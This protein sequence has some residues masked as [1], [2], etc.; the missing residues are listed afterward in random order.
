MKNQILS[1]VAIATLMTLTSCFNNTNKKEKEVATSTAKS[2]V[3]GLKQVD[4]LLADAE[5]LIGKEITVE[6]ICTHLCKHGGSKMFLMGDN[7][8]L[9]IESCELKS[10]PQSCVNSIVRV[11]GTV[12]EERIDEAYLLKWEASLKDEVQDNHGDGEN[13]CETEN[14][15]R[16]E[17]GNTPEERIA[18]FRRRIAERKA[19]TGKEYLSF[20]HVNAISYEI[21]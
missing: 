3:V 15:A 21:Q 18:D 10:F 5:G 11:K 9:R 4:E 19:A 17:T 12:A 20:F 6:G 2:E 1:L 8:T 7:N 16:K 14:A 13:G